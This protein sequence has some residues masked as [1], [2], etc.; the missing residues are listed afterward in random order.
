MT[1]A[2][3]IRALRELIE[4]CVEPSTGH[5]ALCKTKTQIGHAHAR[6][7]KVPNA[8]RAVASL[9]TLSDE[10]AKLQARAFVAGVSFAKP[11]EKLF[12]AIDEADRRYSLRKTGPSKAK[13]REP[14]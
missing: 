1:N 6:W 5:C 10:T 8:E 14:E 4:C 2:P 12:A 11:Y 3:T 13:Q 9:D 7:C